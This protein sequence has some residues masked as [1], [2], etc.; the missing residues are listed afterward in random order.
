M[1]S[2]AKTAGLLMLVVGWVAFFV[3]VSVGVIV[4]AG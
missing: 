4:C 3:G 1:R 2:D